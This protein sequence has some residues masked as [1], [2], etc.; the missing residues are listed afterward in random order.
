[1]GSLF[2]VQ[3][4]AS[5]ETRGHDDFLTCFGSCVRIVD[6]DDVTFLEKQTPFLILYTLFLS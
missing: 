4:D 5:N 6:F 1:M 3:R 2:V